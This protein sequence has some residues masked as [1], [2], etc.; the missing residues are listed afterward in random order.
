MLVDEPLDVAPVIDTVV[1]EALRRDE[2]AQAVEPTTREPDMRRRVPSGLLHA[3]PRLLGKDALHR[4]T[5]QDLRHAVT[6]FH[7]AR[8]AE[9]E[10]DDAVVEEGVKTLQSETGA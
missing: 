1:A 8:Y 9:H 2:I 10:L 7:L 4:P 6:D 5:Q 3:G